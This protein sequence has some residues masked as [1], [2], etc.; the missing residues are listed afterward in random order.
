MDNRALRPKHFLWIILPVCLHLTGST[1]A[2]PTGSPEATLSSRTL[3]A[4]FGS[5][6]GSAFPTNP[7]SSNPTATHLNSIKTNIPT[8]GISS[9]VSSLSGSITPISSHPSVPGSVLSTHPGLTNSIPLNPGS[10]NVQT[11][12]PTSGI[13][14]G[15]SVNPGSFS[16]IS[17]HPSVPGSVLSTHPGL[18]NSI[19]L[20]P[21]S[22]NVQT[23]IPTSGISSG[24]SVN[25]GLISPISSHPSVPG[26]VLST[27][28]GLTNSIPLN[29]GSTNFQTSIPIS[30]ISSGVSSNSGS[31]S[32]ISSHPSIPA[33]VL[34]THLGLTNSVSLNPG[35]TNFQ[36]SIATSGISP[37]VS[38]NSGST[39][40]GSS[41][42]PVSIST[43]NSPVNTF[44][45]L[46]TLPGYP[47]Q[48]L[49]GSSTTISPLPEPTSSITTFTNSP[50]SIGSS[51]SAPTGSTSNSTVSLK[52]GDEA[53]L[54]YWIII[55]IC[56]VCIGAVFLMLCFSFLLCYCLR[57]GNTS[58]V[59]FPMY[60]T[61]NI[62]Q[63]YQSSCQGR[64]Q[65]S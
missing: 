24:L 61:H 23:S 38:S 60:Q 33:S 47:S 13:S 37:G 57:Q 55:L 45:T 25:P 6:T 30:G 64:K 54:T 32:Q 1:L 17:S 29:P 43:N 49:S 27:H 46:P 53:G 42:Y 52:P 36:T 39:N 9:G 7:I 41:S 20:N 15:I 22:T 62:P 65:S 21:G 63:T 5:P 51:G 40:S 56:V 59:C 3:S 2:T 11:S 31:I 48:T 34:S 26:S 44:T 35:S 28:P 19:P 16:P 8:P 18:T 14:S 58:P 10:T 4:S 12:I 50:G